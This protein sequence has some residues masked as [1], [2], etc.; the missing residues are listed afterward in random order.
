MAPTRID[1]LRALS[2]KTLV[3]PE[4]YGP[5]SCPCALH[6]DKRH[7]RSVGRLCNCFRVGPI[8]FLT[9]SEWLNALCWDQTNVMPVGLRYSSPLNGL[10]TGTSMASKGLVSRVAMANPAAATLAAIM[11]S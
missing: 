9:L 5:S 6:R 10:M 1:Q 4:C 2:N 7:D 8:I 11:P 3:R